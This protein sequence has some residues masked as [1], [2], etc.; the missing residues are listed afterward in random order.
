MKSVAFLTM[1]AEQ[2]RKGIE[3]HNADLHE[4]SVLNNKH[5]F[6]LITASLNRLNIEYRL[7]CWILEEEAEEDDCKT[8]SYS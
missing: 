2:L 4:L 1:Y 8:L 3:E 6:D 7:I 5:V